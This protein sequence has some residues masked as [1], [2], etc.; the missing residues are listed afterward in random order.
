MRHSLRWVP[1]C[2]S[3]MMDANSPWY[4]WPTLIFAGIA[5]VTGVWA[6]RFGYNERAKREA[7]RLPRV[8]IHLRE[9]ESDGWY[10]CALNI[11]NRLDAGVKFT[12]AEVI[13]PHGFLLARAGQQLLAL[14]TR[15]GSLRAGQKLS[16]PGICSLSPRPK[17]GA[18]NP[19]RF[20]SVRWCMT[21]TG[22]N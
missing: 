11:R 13:K 9:N 10:P 16:T 19:L 18:P 14:L 17:C 20:L 22:R 7:A 1:F 21:P 5:A 3:V 2:Y 15:I 8:S 4:L 12:R 6:V